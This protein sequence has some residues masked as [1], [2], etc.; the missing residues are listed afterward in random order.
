MQEYKIQKTLWESL[1]SVLYTKGISL[2]KEICKELNVSLQPLATLLKDDDR[3]KF[4]LVPDDDCK[5]QCQAI[6][7]CGSTYMRCRCPSL[8]P[9]PSLCLAHE[10]SARDIPLN[11]PVMQRLVTPEAIYMVNGSEVF[12]LN[13]QKC[14][15]YK[16]S[17][18][19][20]F[21]MVE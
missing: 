20:L 19:T 6:S 5:Y 4:T 9:S 14:G 7:Q 13:G 12:S 17:R 8:K 10:K 18:L 16:N 15:Y 2:A 11:L 1:D 3:S 21:E